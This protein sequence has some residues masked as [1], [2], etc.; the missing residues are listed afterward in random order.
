[1]LGQLA[2]IIR[3]GRS[4]GQ[5]I[6]QAQ[7]AIIGEQIL[8]RTGGRVTL[9]DLLETEASS[10]GWYIIEP[11][12]KAFSGKMIELILVDPHELEDEQDG[13]QLPRKVST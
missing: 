11:K 13:V 8:T 4:G 10:K 6:S 9:Q 1:M 2:S 7:Q 3:Q 12:G 5:F